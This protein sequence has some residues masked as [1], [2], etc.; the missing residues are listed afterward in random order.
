[1]NGY[2]P[3]VLPFS[4]YYAIKTTTLIIDFILNARWYNWSWGAQI[5]I[6][7]DIRRNKEVDLRHA[8]AGVW[9]RFLSFDDNITAQQEIFV[10]LTDIVMMTKNFEVQ[11]K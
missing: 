4:D 2:H 7:S 9:L 5:E 10:R 6:S 3:D 8:P 11:L 1:M